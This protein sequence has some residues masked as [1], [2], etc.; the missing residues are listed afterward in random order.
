MSSAMAWLARLALALRREVDLRRRPARGC[1]AQVVVAD[2]AVEVEGRG[3]ARHRSGTR[4]PR[5]SCASRSAT[6]C[7]TRS[8]SSTDEPFRQVDH[9][10]QLG[11]VVERQQ[12]HRDALGVE[13]RQRG[14]ASQRRRRAGRSRRARAFDAGS[15][16]PPRRRR[17]PSRPPSRVRHGRARHC[18][19][20][21][22]CSI[23]HGVTITATKKENS[24]AAEAFAGIGLI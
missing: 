19:L 13:Q 2:E 4:R 24:I 7:S 5:Q 23:S 18:A 22:T 12:L 9:H 6:A 11:L 15:A 21:R 3:G 17:G 8:V 14:R 1:A 20:R 10:L 16:A